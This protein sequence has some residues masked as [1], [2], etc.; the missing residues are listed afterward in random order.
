MQQGLR[1]EVQLPAW[2]YRCRCRALLLV[3]LSA[4]TAPARS[5][6]HPPAALHRRIPTRP[7]PPATAPRRASGS[8][9]D[10]GLA[11]A[12]GARPTA[13]LVRGKL[14]PQGQGARYTRRAELGRVRARQ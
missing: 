3:A 8:C 14:S 4:A 11:T 9:I 10:R 7:A 5:A 6:A 12:S 2:V 1:P 13:V